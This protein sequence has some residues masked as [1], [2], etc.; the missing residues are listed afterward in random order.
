MKQH[1]Q[2]VLPDSALLAEIYRTVGSVPDY[3]KPDG[4]TRF[5]TNGKPSNADGWVAVTPNGRIHFGC[6]RQG[7][8]GCWPEQG[9]V[10]A[11]AAIPLMRRKRVSVNDA[12]KRE[13]QMY[14]NNAWWTQARSV[15]AQ[16]PAGRYLT[17]R[18]LALVDYPA[19]LRVTR[20]N[21]YEDR[22]NQGEFDVMLGAVTSPPG[23]LVG[24]HRTFLTSD[25]KKAPVPNPKKMTVTSAP[26]PGASIKLYA[27]TIIE[28]KMTLGVAEGIETALACQLGW[29]IPTWSCVSASGMK[30][31]IWPTQVESL[32]I[33]ADNDPAGL[34]AARDLAARAAPAGI[35]VRILVP[36]TARA[37]WLDIYLG[38]AE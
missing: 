34:I 4:V 9:N 11:Y 23:S 38:V 18:G 36:K 3:I 33:F 29:A 25:G 32:V 26:L 22:V 8:R 14:V 30:T 24:L 15:S 7:V 10:A 13:R 21:Y 28:G 20:M 17:N 12:D 16:S 37:D 2:P 6:W 19:A 1:R 27:P 35:E 5:S 31:F